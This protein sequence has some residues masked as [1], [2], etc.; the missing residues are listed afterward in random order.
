MMT[1]KA[2]SSKVTNNDKTKLMPNKVIMFMRGKKTWNKGSERKAIL[3]TIKEKGKTKQQ[4][5]NVL[6]VTRLKRNMTNKGGVKLK[7][8]YEKGA[9]KVIVLSIEGKVEQNNST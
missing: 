3:L 5:L 9:G 2:R 4:S 7:E 1:T 8:R 6:L